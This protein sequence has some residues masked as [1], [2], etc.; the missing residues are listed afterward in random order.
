MATFPAHARDG[1]ELIAA[2]DAALLRAKD[3]GRNR[4]VLATGKMN[5]SE[6]S[7]GPRTGRRAATQRPDP[8]G[9]GAA[10]SDTSPVGEG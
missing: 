6:G 10:D 9:S 4:T 7:D 8:S 2:A 1:E 3:G 5:P